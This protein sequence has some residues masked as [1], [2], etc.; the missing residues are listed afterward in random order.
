MDI[1]SPSR[2]TPPVDRALF[3]SPQEGEKTPT[4]SAEVSATPL[5]PTHVRVR[6][7]SRRL[8]FSGMTGANPDSLP[9]V[10]SSTPVRSPVACSVSLVS[11]P[12]DLGGS[13][14]TSTPIK[15][16]PPPCTHSTPSPLRR[17]FLVGR[18]LATPQKRAISAL[19]AVPTP[20]RT[21][22]AAMVLR[23]IGADCGVDVTNRDH[24]DSTTPVARDLF[25]HLRSSPWASGVADQM[26]CVIDKASAARRHPSA[27]EVCDIRLVD[28][29]H[30]EGGLGASPGLVKSGFHCCPSDHPMYD[31]LEKKLRNALTQVWQAQVPSTKG[32]KLSTLYPQF[33]LDTAR[34]DRAIKD[35]RLIAKDTV[36]AS[37]LCSI[38]YE[39]HEMV[40]T[41]FLNQRLP[42]EWQVISA[43]PVFS[44]TDLTLDGTS[45]EVEVED[46]IS[47]LVISFTRTKEDIVSQ[48]RSLSRDVFRRLVAFE[49]DSSYIVDIAHLLGGCPIKKGILVSI[50][51]TILS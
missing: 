17:P 29:D 11:S 28:L 12:P 23:G 30:I 2:V 38:T 43:F 35:R 32:F 26:R 18:P 47:S 4:A 46:M 48:L 33:C 41:I 15:A 20:D 5:P 49:T 42:L 40:V 50:P 37:R 27:V 31:R 21:R 3:F 24:V 7:V 44:Y 22:F 39:G 13:T 36:R 8:V 9:S 10:A 14:S 1:S 16:P 19:G 51:K 25:Q 6:V 45:V 34:L